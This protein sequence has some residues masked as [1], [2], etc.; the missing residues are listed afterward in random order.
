[1]TS[2]DRRVGSA[3]ASTIRAHLAQCSNS[4]VPALHERVDLDAY[5][6]KIAGRAVSFEAW[7]GTELV[8]LVAAYLNDLESRVAFVTNV[9]VFPKHQGQGL[10][11]QLL[12]ACIEEARARGFATVRLEVS[13]EAAPALALY[14]RAGFVEIGRSANG[15]TMQLALDTETGR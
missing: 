9:S 1:V 14:E 8:G 2:L 11:R 15:L 7:D 10:A 4:F 3:D 6:Q 5:A 12:G 13:P